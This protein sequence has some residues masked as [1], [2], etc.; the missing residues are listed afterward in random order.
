[1]KTMRASAALLGGLM[2]AAAAGSAQAATPYE[3]EMYAQSVAE[4][5]YPTGAGAVTGGL[6]G[7]LIGAG[8]AGATGGNVG[9]GAG[10]GAGVGL[11]VG[12][13]AWRAKKEEARRLAYA[14]CIGG[15][16]VYAP[17][18]PVYAP[19]VLPTGPFNAVISGASAVNVRQ[20][21][22]TNFA[23]VGQVVQGQMV[24]IAGCGGGWCQLA[25]GYG[26]VSQ[27]YV[28]PI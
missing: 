6:F 8:I 13:S 2:I 9:T 23:I 20:G 12:S 14:Q 1:M 19:P 21:P 22:G 18:P 26:Y 5:Q 7:G 16:P 28:Y 4:Q 3:C 11:V 17:G 15:T 25:G 24:G 27:S 10:V